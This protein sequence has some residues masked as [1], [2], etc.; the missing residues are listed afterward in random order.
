MKNISLIALLATLPMLSFAQLDLSLR[1]TRFASIG[2]TLKDH[3]LFRLESS[4]FSADES[5]QNGRMYVGYTNE[6]KGIIGTILPYAGMAWNTDYKLVGANINAKYNILGHAI[7]EVTYN[8]HWDSIYG[9]NHCYMTGVETPITKEVSFVARFQN[10]PEYRVVAKRVRVGMKFKVNNLMIK[11]EISFA[12][13]KELE[14][15][16]MMVDFSYSFPNT[17]I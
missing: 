6:I 5:Y 14:P 11:P 13:K 2:Y 16:R 12:P 10:I 4:V 9:F 3:W 8:P 1:D 17:K 15:I 7:I